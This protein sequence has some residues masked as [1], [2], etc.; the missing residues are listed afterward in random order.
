MSRENV[1][2]AK[3]LNEAVRCGD[4]EAAIPFWP[5]TWSRSTTVIGLPNSAVTTTETPRRSRRAASNAPALLG[6]FDTH[7]RELVEAARRSGPV[8]DYAAHRG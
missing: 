4:I 3:R 1:E 8:R 5:T 6:G 7:S 2:L